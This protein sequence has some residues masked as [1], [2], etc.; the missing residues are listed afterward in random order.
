ME[1]IHFFFE[2]TGHVKVSKSIVRSIIKRMAEDYHVKTGMINIV[3]CTD[4]FLLD[5]NKKFLNHDYYTDIVTFDNHEKGFISGELY[6]SL[7]RVEENAALFREKY[8]YELIRVIIH[9]VLHLIGK[10]DKTKKESDRM[11][12][13]EDFYLNKYKKIEK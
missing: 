12:E 2:E 9:G 5:I 3:F 13:E 4:N 6:I 7:E 11:R 10:C 1:R 8:E